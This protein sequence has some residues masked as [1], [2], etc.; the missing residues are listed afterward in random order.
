MERQG[1]LELG[2]PCDR[3]LEVSQRFAE[4]SATE[5]EREAALWAVQAAKEEAV[6]AQKFDRA[7][8]IRDK[9]IVVISSPLLEREVTGGRYWRGDASRLFH[10]I[11]GDPF[12]P[13]A[14][15]AIWP[16]AVVA[17]AKAIHRQGDCSFALHDAL[18]DAGHPDL[19]SHFREADE[20][21]PAGC[22]V[23]DL[24]LGKK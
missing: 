11:V 5:R 24:L 17:L 15:P 21:H 13:Y 18:L 2:P 16:E 9:E 19:A 23:L 6:M 1:C 12:H 20:P 22:W 14:A 10:H 7:A 8:A 3:A 4:G